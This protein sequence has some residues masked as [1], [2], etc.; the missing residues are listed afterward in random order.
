MSKP[1]RWPVL[2]ERGVEAETLT[3]LT[4]L[5]SADWAKAGQV[6]WAAASKK[7]IKLVNSWLNRACRERPQELGIWIER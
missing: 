4:Q 3:N 1:I 2:T 5:A 6:S 7:S